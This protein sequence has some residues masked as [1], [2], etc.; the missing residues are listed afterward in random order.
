MNYSISLMA[1]SRPGIVFKNGGVCRTRAGRVYGILYLNGAFHMNTRVS[2]SVDVGFRISTSNK[3]LQYGIEQIL[4]KI[5]RRHFNGMSYVKD[6]YHKSHEV[7][8][9]YI[10][11][12]IDVD[13]SFIVNEFMP[14]SSSVA[15]CFIMP[16][17]TR[18]HRHKGR[19]VIYL[20]QPF[21]VVEQG[22]T[23]A[24]KALIRPTSLYNI[25]HSRN[26]ELTKRQR[27]VLH[28]LLK[29]SC[30]DEIARKSNMTV[31]TV[32]SHRR[33]IYSKLGVRN[34]AEFYKQKHLVE[35]L[36]SSDEVVVEPRNRYCHLQ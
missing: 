36:Y 10:F 1:H 21:R 24:I 32:Y 33:M 12:T 30:V 20:H 31:K 6:C 15:F 7:K 4:E 25:D 18:R 9:V 3:Y 29:G 35:L 16:E 34:M 17:R 26:I 14:H 11:H 28:Y 19:T 13:A 27:E 5:M 22:L 23:A 2:E 8:P